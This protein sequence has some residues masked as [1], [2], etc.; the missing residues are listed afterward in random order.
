MWLHFYW[1]GHRRKQGCD[2]IRGKTWRSKDHQMPLLLK[3]HWFG[4]SHTMQC[5]WE[6]FHL[7]LSLA[8]DLSLS[9]PPFLS[10]FWSLSPHPSSLSL[11]CYIICKLIAWGNVSAS[12]HVNRCCRVCVRVCACGRVCMGV[13]HVLESCIASMCA[14]LMSEWQLR[15][16]LRWCRINSY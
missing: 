10:C 11:G 5:Y 1:P 13:F 15:G 16:C 6:L 14:Y 12:E 8:F 3:S 7:S 4:G 2:W 9:L